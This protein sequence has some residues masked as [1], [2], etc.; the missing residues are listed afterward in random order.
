MKPL[1]RS[2]FRFCCKNL[3]HIPAPKL[4]YRKDG[5]YFD[6]FTHQN[7]LSFRKN[8]YNQ[9]ALSFID[10]INMYIEKYPNVSEKQLMYYIQKW[11]MRGMVN[12][13]VNLYYGWF[14]FDESKCNIDQYIDAIPSRIL[15]HNHILR[16]QINNYKRFKRY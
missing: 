7:N 10:L 6:D 4:E 16:N 1:E 2:F 14:K 9:F 12:Y 15:S 8:P 13:G 11:E 5:I 3:K